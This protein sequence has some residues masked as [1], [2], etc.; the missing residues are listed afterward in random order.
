MVVAKNTPIGGQVCGINEKKNH[1]KCGSTIACNSVLEY[2]RVEGDYEV[3]YP[4]CSSFVGF[5][6]PYPSVK[7][8]IDLVE[9]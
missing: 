7:R 3:Q 2:V 8:M 4:T 6:V 9:E 5:F 1:L